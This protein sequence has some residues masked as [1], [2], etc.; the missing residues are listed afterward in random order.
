MAAPCYPLIVLD[1][2]T[3]KGFGIVEE[4]DH[5]E[6]GNRELYPIR[7]RRHSTIKRIASH[8]FNGRRFCILYPQSHC[9][10]GISVETPRLDDGIQHVR[11]CFNIRQCL[12]DPETVLSFSKVDFNLF[13]EV[14]I[15]S[16]E[17]GAGDC[18]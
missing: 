15:G 3:D 2:G 9:Q 8:H 6:L 4:G 17:S 18:F 1:I 11:F 5:R 16:T 10:H 7:E 12:G 13:E 14:S